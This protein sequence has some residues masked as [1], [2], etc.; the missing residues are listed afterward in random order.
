MVK[1][2]IAL[3]NSTK[4]TFV[5]K[6]S[7]F[8]DLD[9]FLRYIAV[10]RAIHNADGIMTWYCDTA[11]GWKGNHN[12]YF[13]EEENPGG[14]LWLIPWDLPATLTK[15]DPIIDDYDVPEWNVTPA[16][17][18]AM[19]IWGGSFGVPPN[20]DK[21]TKLTAAALWDNFKAVGGQLLST[22]F[23]SGRLKRNLDTLAVIAEPVVAQDPALDVKRWRGDVKDLRATLTVLDTGFDDYIHGRTG[24][25]DT[26]GFAAPFCDSAFLRIDCLNN[27]E[28]PAAAGPRSWV[29]GWATK[30]STYSPSLDTLAPLWGKSDL[31]F[32]FALCALDTPTAHYSEGAMMN[33]PFRNTTDCTGLKRIRM[34]LKCD[35]SRY[36]F[37]SLMSDVYEQ[38]GAK[39]AYGWSFPVSA[40]SKEYTLDMATIGYSSSRENEDPGILD[41][42]LLSM[43]GIGVWGAGRFN[44]LGKLMVSPDSGYVRVDN[45]IFEK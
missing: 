36:C 14:K 25:V 8:M 9:Y 28:L 32:S 24:I 20:C 5:Q 33:L 43:K 1:L 30:G 16:S 37:I 17:C 2:F 11:S 29:S 35:V 42:V 4:E 19:P 34:H 3:Q 26:A 10:D 7:P 45:V 27:F 21:L 12:F 13:Y 18:K 44:D 41:T 31:L 39:S 23:K 40:K 6:V 38:K 22:F 15:T